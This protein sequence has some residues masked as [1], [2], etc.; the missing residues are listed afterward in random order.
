MPEALR[1]DLGDVIPDGAGALRN[2]WPALAAQVARLVSKRRGG[3]ERRRAPNA[4]HTVVWRT[5]APK[6]LENVAYFEHSDKA[7]KMVPAQGAQNITPT[8]VS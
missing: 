3:T 1:G 5:G 2:S 6:V 4:T 7:P 8:D